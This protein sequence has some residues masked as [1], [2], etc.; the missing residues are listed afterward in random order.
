MAFWNDEADDEAVYS[1][2]SKAADEVSSRTQEL[3]LG[4]PFV[5]LN[6]AAKPQRPFE[7]Y[8]AGGSSLRRLKDVRKKYDPDGF[9][10]HYLQHGFGL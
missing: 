6:D 2:V 1:F 4:L 3:G 9:F 10:Q 8:G 7:T 5:Y